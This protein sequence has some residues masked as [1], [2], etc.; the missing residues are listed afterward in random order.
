MRSEAVAMTTNH[1]RNSLSSNENS[2]TEGTDMH[3]GRPEK[4]MPSEGR[5]II[6]NSGVT[7]IN[8]SIPSRQKSVTLTLYGTTAIIEVRGGAVW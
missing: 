4:T 3:A 2:R 1:Q 8:V 5:L 7:R 6:I